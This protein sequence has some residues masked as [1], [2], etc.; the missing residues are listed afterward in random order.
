M[1]SMYAESH[2]TD[3]VVCVALLLAGCPH[4]WNRRT[5][6]AMITDCN[7]YGECPSL[8]WPDD[9]IVLTK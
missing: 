3:H 7:K 8:Y 1:L 5:M 6:S 4:V 2:L 9:V